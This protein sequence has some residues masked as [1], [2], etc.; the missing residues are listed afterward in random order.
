MH[1]RHR[2]NW[3]VFTALYF[4]AYAWIFPGGFHYDDF[5]SIRENSWL[6]SIANIP[7]FFVNPVY[8][9]KTPRAAMYRPVLLVSYALDYQIFGWRASGWH[10]TN[11]LMHLVNSLLVYTL[12]AKTLGRRRLAWI[13][14]LLFA[15]QPVAGENVNYL[16]CRSSILLSSF[17]LAGLLCV[18]RFKQARGAG[19]FWAALACFCYILA[20]L[21]KDSAAVFPGMAFL[22]FWIFSGEQTGQKLWRSVGLLLPMAVVL[23][24][25]LFLRNEFFESVFTGASLPRSRLDNLFTELKAYFWY[26]GLFLWPWGL[27]IEHGFR[28]EHSFYE[29]LVLLSAAGLATLGAVV[30]AALIRPRSRF[31]IPGFFIGFYILALLPTASI[32]PLN[33]LVSERALYPALFALA[34]LGA[35]FVDYVMEK[36]R[37]AGIFAL[38]LVLFCYAAVLY[39]RGRAWQ[40]E[41]EIWRDAYEHAPDNARVLA[42]LGRQYF[43]G[44]ELKK[45]L[46]YSLKS[47]ELLSGRA[48]TLF[49]LATIYMDYGDL[50]MAENY[51]R[52]GLEDEPEDV[53]ARVN[54]AAVCQAEGKMEVAV[55][56]LEQ[57]LALDPENSLAHSNLGDVYFNLGRMDKAEAEFRKALSINPRLELANYN[58]GILLA[59]RGDYSQALGYF[60]KAF[61]QNA[62]NADYALWAGIMELK[63]NRPQE[64]E[65]WA[66]KAL[67]LDNGYDRAWYYLGLARKQQGRRKEAQ[68]AFIRAEKFDRG[69]D[70]QLTSAIK[71]LL[72]ELARK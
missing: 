47:E 39:S 17:L 15:F 71:D 64:A 27:S 36:K 49:N 67:A 20:L 42:E 44:G 53:E 13:A 58:L 40:S 37:R 7:K 24:G 1:M 70:P 50:A 14:C 35:L 22:Y 51:F 5:H 41:R 63:L 43:A 2:T 45:A 21:T 4:L 61:A 9:S 12:V 25:Y 16:N 56:E 62:G 30:A 55:H 68:E 48:P 57:A 65:R 72:R 28:V 6:S 34:S 3:L 66:A 19:I 54:L 18:E 32:I 8:F 52:Q 59:G 60:V 29:P 69:A 23:G 38:G 46:R 31:A 10:L 26:G 33:V 11:L